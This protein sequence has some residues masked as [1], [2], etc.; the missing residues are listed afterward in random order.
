MPDANEK[1][2]LHELG[3]VRNAKAPGYEIARKPQPEGA[4]RYRLTQ[5]TYKYGKLWEV[6][7]IISV[8]GPAAPHM[9]PVDDDPPPVSKTEGRPKPSK[10]VI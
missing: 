2:S 10:D 1:L 3:N 7:E 9:V 6:G 5:Q 8:V 4:K